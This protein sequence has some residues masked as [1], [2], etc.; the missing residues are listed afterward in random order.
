MVYYLTFPHRERQFP[1]G[2]LDSFGQ[3]I[4]EVAGVR[5]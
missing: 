3:V 4:C 2:N 5:D 1:V